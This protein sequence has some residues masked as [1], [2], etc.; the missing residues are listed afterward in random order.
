MSCHDHTLG[1]TVPTAESEVETSTLGQSSP[2]APLSLMLGVTEVRQEN[3]EHL[4]R[5]HSWLLKDPCLS[6]LYVVLPTPFCSTRY[7]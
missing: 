3:Q 7:L 2:P 1:P 5:E 4:N 6:M